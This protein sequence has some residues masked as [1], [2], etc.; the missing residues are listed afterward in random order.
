MAAIQRGETL[1]EA[2]KATAWKAQV[3]LCARYRRLQRAGK[4]TDV[5]AVAIAC[6]LAAFV[7][8]IATITVPPL[9]QA[10]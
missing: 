6:E 3:R 4:P 5:I 2:V 1:S 10:P 7:W 9:E 8:A